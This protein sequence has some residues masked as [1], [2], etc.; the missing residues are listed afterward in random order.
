MTRRTGWTVAVLAL[1]LTACGS[2]AA[3]ATSTVSPAEL[4]AMLL[5]VDELEGID[6]E[7]TVKADTST[8]DLG[9]I[10]RAHV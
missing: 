10:G 5:T 1:A 4:K 6:G 8:A 3:P 9:K 2:D 7:W